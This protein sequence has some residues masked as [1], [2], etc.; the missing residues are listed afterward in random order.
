MAAANGTTSMT[1]S[2]ADGRGLLD[3]AY[4]DTLNQVK[5]SMAKHLGKS[6]AFQKAWVTAESRAAHSDRNRS[7]PAAYPPGTCA[8][9][10]ALLLLMVDGALPAAMTE[11]WFSSD[12]SKTQAAIEYIDNQTGARQVKLEKFKPGQTVTPCELLVLLLICDGGKPSCEHKI[13]NRS[14]RSCC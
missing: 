1:V 8:A 11:Q 3:A 9:Q 7:G 14:R 6:L 5:V 4:L 10:G 12:G 13:Q 2:Y